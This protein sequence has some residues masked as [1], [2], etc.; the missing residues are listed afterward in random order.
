MY[1]KPQIALYVITSR[2]DQGVHKVSVYSESAWYKQCR[3]A[4][5]HRQRI[6]QKYHRPNHRSDSRHISEM[7]EVLNDINEL[8]QSTDPQQS[9]PRRQLTC[10]RDLQSH[11][12]CPQV[13]TLPLPVRLQHL[14]PNLDIDQSRS[15]VLVR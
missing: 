3:Q 1:V 7:L 8:W 10:P 15:S 6:A 4:R 9:S 14:R 5:H 12:N 13:L 2:R 11:R